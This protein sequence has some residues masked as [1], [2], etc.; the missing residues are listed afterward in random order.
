VYLYYATCDPCVAQR[1]R[2]PKSTLACIQRQGTGGRAGQSEGSRRAVHA[3]LVISSDKLYV[4]ISITPHSTTYAYD[5]WHST[6]AA[7]KARLHIAAEYL[8][9]GG[10]GPLVCWGGC[11]PRC[12]A[13]LG[14]P[15][16][17]C[18]VPPC[19]GRCLLPPPL[20]WFLVLCPPAVGVCCPPLRWVLVLCP[21]A[22]GVCCPLP[23]RACGGFWPRVPVPPR[24]V[25]APTTLGDDDSQWLRSALPPSLACSMETPREQ[26]PARPRVVRW[27]W[28]DG[29]D[30]VHSR[31]RHWANHHSPVTGRSRGAATNS[32]RGR[33]GQSEGEGSR[34]AAHAHA[35]LVRYELY[36]IIICRVYLYFTPLHAHI[37]IIDS[38]QQRGDAEHACT[39]HSGRVLYTTVGS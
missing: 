35:P 32:T 11:P 9:A 14:A 38:W 33:A 3:S 12:C 16:L 24:G 2:S 22:V 28:D 20:W 7:T 15:A 18:V 10:S 25:V 26:P 27:G 5:P 39:A 36:H 31:S 29:A 21:P 19:G 13:P 23:P 17:Q 8:L 30:V 34:R 4:C 1:R 6:V 37:I